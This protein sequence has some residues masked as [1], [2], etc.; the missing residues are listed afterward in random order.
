MASSLEELE[1]NMASMAVEDK[2]IVKKKFESLKEE[3]SVDINSDLDGVIRLK[4]LLNVPNMDD[5]CNTLQ[6]IA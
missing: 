1:T 3:E 6:L 4:R 2:D 5:L